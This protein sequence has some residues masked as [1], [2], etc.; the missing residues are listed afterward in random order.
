MS[1]INISE[2]TL[3]VKDKDFSIIKNECKEKGI[4]VKEGSNELENLYLLTSDR[5]QEPANYDE[6]SQLQIQSDGVILEKGSNKVVCMAHNKLEE[7][8]N[9]DDV[10]NHSKNKDNKNFRLEFCEDGTMIRLYNYKN[11]WHTATSRCLDAKNS[12]WSS[13]RSF[14]EMFWEIF[15]KSILE[16]LDK[17]YT[18]CFILVHIE[19]RI[20]IKHKYNNLVYLCRVNNI[21]FMEDYI[22]QFY[23]VYGFRRPKQIFEQNYQNIYK[24]LKDLYHPKKRGILIKFFNKDDNT[25][26]VYKYDYEIYKNIKELRGN[27]PEMRMR[28]LELLNQPDSL[29]LLQKYYYEYQLL[30]E[31]IKTSLHKITQNIHKLYINSHVKHNIQVEETHLFYKTL[32]Q[33]HGQYKK[34]NVPITFQDVEN[35]LYSFDTKIIR[36]LLEWSQ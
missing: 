4:F 25:W 14:D 9:I 16:S 20:V 28:Y 2:I 36:R 3:F 26:K 10:F 5:E 17:D 23:N 32:R 24:Y 35:K 34:T 18:Y 21:T 12:Y 7:T 30:F 15:D 19:N 27:V 29:E 8:S 6:L 1:V 13:K 31:I 11:N 33:L 22:N